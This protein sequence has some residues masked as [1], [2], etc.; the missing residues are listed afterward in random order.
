M[1]PARPIRAT[2]GQRGSASS[3]SAALQSS[4]ASRLRARLG[5]AGSTV[6][7]MTWKTQG[8]P[9]GRR[10]SRLQAS[11]R[12]CGE[13]AYGSWPTPLGNDAKNSDYS[14]TNG[15]PGRPALKL[16]GA[17]KLACWMTPTARDHK[18]GAANLARVPVNALLGRQV[19]LTHG[20][21]RHGSRAPTGSSA[22]LNPAHSRWLMG[23][24]PAW[25]DCAVTAMRSFRNSRP[26]SSARIST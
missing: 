8:M 2:F 21:P 16:P 23:F 24:P 15:Q 26:E 11:A 19:L 20:R 10:I 12:S 5:S 14:Y 9:S 4:L 1:G 3:A 7:S 18:D 6:Y 25:D 22:L 17:A 13:T